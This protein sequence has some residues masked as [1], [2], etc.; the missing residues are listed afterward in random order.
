MLNFLHCK[1]FAA[2]TTPARIGIVEIK[3]FSIETV[4]E[5]EFGIHE[6]KKALVFSIATP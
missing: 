2:A 5:F 6:I 3:T 1:T 4:A